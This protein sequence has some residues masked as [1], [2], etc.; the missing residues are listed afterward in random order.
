MKKKTVS[1]ETL[2]SIQPSLP[3]SHADLR[4]EVEALSKRVNALI[5][6]IN[7]SFTEIGNGF[8]DLS[9]S[10]AAIVDVVGEDKVTDAAVKIHVQKLELESKRTDEGIVLLKQQGL[11]EDA[12]TIGAKSIVVVTQRAPTGNV[13]HPERCHVE[14]SRMEPEVAELL[15][16]KA[17]GDKVELK[18]GDTV[19]V[20]E[21]FQETQKKDA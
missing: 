2:A 1:K 13:R 17:K 6:E 15:N 3:L 16:G 10:V 14:F 9:Q 5:N 20:I 18:S 21:I 19:E 8:K 11:L 12:A 4:Q 7:T